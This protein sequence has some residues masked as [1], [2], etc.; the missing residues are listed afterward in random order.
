MA[1]IKFPRVLTERDGYRV[2]ATGKV[3]LGYYSGIIVERHYKDAAG[4]TS[5]RT[6]TTD[7]SKNDELAAKL[8]AMALLERLT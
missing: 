3:T 1:A 4:D 5:W 2:V 7:S 6:F 8:L